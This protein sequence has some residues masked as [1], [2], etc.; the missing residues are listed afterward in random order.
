MIIL[1]LDGVLADFSSAALRAVGL[2]SGTV[3]TH[4]NW[5]HDFGI[6]DEQFWKRI[7]DLGAEFYGEYVKPYPWAGD[8]IQAVGDADDFVVMTA[9]SNHPEG[10]AGKKIWVDKYLDLDPKQLIVGSRKELLAGPDRLLI[11]DGPHNLDAFKAAGGLVLMFPQP[12]NDFGAA[13]ATLD[14]IRAALERWT[15]LWN[16]ECLYADFYV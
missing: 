1:D 4:W 2:P 12:W 10:Y 8:L 3:P 7:H 15:P 5:Y 6:T 11:D 16:G 9:P 14:G 13:P